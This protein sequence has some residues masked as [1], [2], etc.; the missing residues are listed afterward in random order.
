[1]FNFVWEDGVFG[2]VRKG[3]FLKE[4]VVFRVRDIV[5]FEVLEGGVVGGG[6]EVGLLGFLLV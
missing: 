3:G 2:E 5:I 6:S 4:S 1:M